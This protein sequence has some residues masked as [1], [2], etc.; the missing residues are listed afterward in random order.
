MMR[1]NPE[2]IDRFRKCIDRGQIQLT[3]TGYSHPI[4]PA[5][6]DKIG[7][8]AV[9]QQIE[10]D[11][12]L[13]N[14]LFGVR[15]RV[16]RPPEYA[17]DDSIVKIAG[18]YFD[19]VLLSGLTFKLAGLPDRYAINHG[20]V[21]SIG[22]HEGLSNFLAFDYLRNANSGDFVNWLL[23]QGKAITDLDGE[24]FI[25]HLLLNGVPMETALRALDEIYGLAEF[26][27]IETLHI[28]EFADSLPSVDRHETIPMTSYEGGLDTWVGSQEHER[29]WDNVS[30]AW[31]LYE[32]GR[33][34]HLAPDKLRIMETNALRA[35]TSCFPW[36]ISRGYGE[37]WHVQPETYRAENEIILQQAA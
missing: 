26:S 6:L 29:L 14:D 35:Q 30:G 36:G 16:F 20:N 15:P 21:K 7:E 24:T 23:Y 27:G 18:E 8:G 25:H 10:R 28:A 17:V 12:A 37:W 11:L 34:K 19:Y 9:R 2:L 32:A 4:L 33:K 13:K 5:L 1:Y 31:Q 3:S 22:R